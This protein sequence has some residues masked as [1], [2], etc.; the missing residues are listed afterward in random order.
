MS[1][2]SV[3]FLIGNTDVRDR[4]KA[5]LASKCNTVWCYDAFI[6]VWVVNLKFSTIKGQNYQFYLFKSCTSKLISM[7]YFVL[8]NSI[9]TQDCSA[10]VDVLLPATE[11]HIFE[12][13][14]LWCSL[15]MMKQTFLWRNDVCA[16]CW[17]I[18]SAHKCGSICHF[19][20]D[21]SSISLAEG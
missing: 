12:S 13:K 20:N 5:V 3:F 19:K 6:W 8:L 14:V 17:N 1:L 11:C 21:A 16:S 15:V 9:S 7:G 2:K 4:G 10:V 18:L